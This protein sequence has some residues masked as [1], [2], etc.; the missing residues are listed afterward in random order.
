MFVILRLQLEVDADSVWNALRSPASMTDLYAPLLTMASADSVPLPPRWNDGAT[1]EVQL[2][3][4]GVV[5]GGRQRIDIRLRRRGGVR[6]LEDHGAPT[7]GPL[8]VITSWRHRM[9]VEE[10][11]PGR[12]LY[13]DRLDI[14]AGALTPLLWIGFWAMWRWRG[15]RMRHLLTA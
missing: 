3:A 7:S 11:G 4:C 10:I 5:P 13:R 14:E 12:T 1:A 8:T 2:M 15:V 6:I 9:A